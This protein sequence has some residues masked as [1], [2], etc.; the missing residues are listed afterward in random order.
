MRPTSIPLFANHALP[1]VVGASIREADPVFGRGLR[2]LRGA[3]RG[4]RAGIAADRTAAALEQRHQPRR[5]L[6][7]EPGLGDG[8]P[9]GELDLLEELAVL[10]R[11]V[12][13]ARGQ[14]RPAG[15][16]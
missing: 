13:Q 3:R 10:G 4:E 2:E 8:R 16:E 9:D 5:L 1:W 12:G 7:L 15:A 11:R 6:E 14:L